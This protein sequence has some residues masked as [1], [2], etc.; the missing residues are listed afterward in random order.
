MIRYIAPMSWAMRMHMLTAPAS[1][2]NDK[3]STVK[4]PL[5]SLAIRNVIMGCVRL[6]D[7]DR[8]ARPRRYS[9]SQG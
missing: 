5:R 1:D 6:G 8:G 7:P 2:T 4:V 3:P 9:P